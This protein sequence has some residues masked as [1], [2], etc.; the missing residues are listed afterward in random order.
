MELYYNVQK[1]NG[2]PSLLLEEKSWYD[3]NG[4]L[5]GPMRQE[6]DALAKT[7]GLAPNG[8]G[9]YASGNGATTFQALRMMR[10]WG[11]SAA[12]RAEMAV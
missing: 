11:V 9:S 12:Y 8:A 7:A 2:Q 3:L 4:N 5:E 10:S 6:L 1:V